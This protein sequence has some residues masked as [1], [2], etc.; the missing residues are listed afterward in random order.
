M[1]LIQGYTAPATPTGTLSAFYGATN[2]TTAP[3]S[4]TA[5]LG[6]WVL[7]TP[8]WTAGG[9]TLTGED[10]ATSWSVS[11]AANGGT[12][13]TDGL[14]RIA[15]NETATSLT[16]TATNVRTGATKTATLALA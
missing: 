16:V 11:G 9:S 3:T 12:R 7:Y 1:A 5:N 15:S 6:S 13:I 4:A 2:S 10:A 8:T 14:L